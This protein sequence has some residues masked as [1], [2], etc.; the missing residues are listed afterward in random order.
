LGQGSSAILAPPSQLPGH[1]R[2]ASFEQFGYPTISPQ[3]T[4][5]NVP[6]RFQH[7]FSGSQDGS[8]LDQYQYSPTRAQAAISQ[9]Q[10]PLSPD[11]G[12][13]GS[14]GHLIDPHA[15]YSPSREGATIPYNPGESFLDQ[16]IAELEGR[17][18]SKAPVHGYTI[19]SNGHTSS[20]AL[21]SA[22]AQAPAPNQLPLPGTP[23]RASLG[24]EP[25]RS[26]IV[27]GVPREIEHASII[28]LFP[29]SC[30]TRLKMG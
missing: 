25:R 7:Q 24:I 21:S 6:G 28:E 11:Q 9:S 23:G 8:P 20:Q 19:D 4:P 13:T 5:S 12:G 1:Q 15:R 10:Y 27:E 16:V 30:I 14:G 2:Q 29:V 3:L 26:I 17:Q 22:L 18:T